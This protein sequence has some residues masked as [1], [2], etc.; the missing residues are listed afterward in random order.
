MLTD[1]EALTRILAR[2]GPLPS[3]RVALSSALHAFAM[4]PMHATVPLPGFDNSAMDGYA[5]RA[6]DTCTQEPLRV[7]GALA[8]GDSA[9][10]KLEPGCAIRIFTGAAMPP[11]ADAV[12]MQ[13]DVTTLDGENTIMCR[14]A[15][16]PGENVRVLGC[17]L[18]VGQH[19]VAAGDRLTPQRLAVLAS[20][21]LAK[22]EVATEPRIGIVTT[23]DEL[24][25]P[26]AIL[27]S[28]M[29]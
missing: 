6:T 2:I 4:R 28:G 24:I 20:Q 11:G 25:C 18:C 16:E 21:G 5:V 13:E 3:H 1:S 15:V 27:Q 29:L 26:S 17:D 19:I 8:A 9:K 12:I 14:E 10:F 23:G 22:V 7:T